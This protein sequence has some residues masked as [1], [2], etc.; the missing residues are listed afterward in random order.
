MA[1]NDRN[2]NLVTAMADMAIFSTHSFPTYWDSAV[3]AA[4]P[5]WLVVDANWAEQDLQHWIKAGRK[6]SAKVAFEP[7][8]AAKSERLF[9]PI[10]GNKVVGVFP[11][12]PIVDL[13]TPNQYEL[14]AMYAAALRNE[15]FESATNGWF[16]IIDAFGIRGG[17]RD[18]FVRLCGMEATDA[19]I[20]V[21]SVNLLPY[22][23][24][25][26]TKMGSKGALLTQILRP[27]DERLN[28]P[29]EMDFIL[30]RATNGHPHVGG[31]YMRFFETVEDVP[32]N[33]IVSVNAVGDTFL[34][35]LIA[36]LAQGGRVDKL[37]DVAQRAAVMTLR[38]HGG[39]SAELGEMMAGLREAVDN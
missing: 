23:P 26:V 8:S 12:R 17:A 11:K 22:I 31:V 33:D 38:S 5:K 28:D 3:A 34:G 27:E 10:K 32:L 25:I 6:H 39:V 4:K 18:K 21:Q 20:P 1:V 30:T 15:Y 36:G 37:V 14:A 2:K 9:P 19:G 35:V 13:A 16:E 24:T 7:V 29:E